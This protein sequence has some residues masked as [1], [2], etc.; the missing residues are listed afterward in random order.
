MMRGVNFLCFIRPACIPLL[1][2][3]F[4]VN[5]SIAQ[6]EQYPPDNPSDQN[7]PRVSLLLSGGGTRASAFSYGVLYQLSKICYSESTIR[8]F[9]GSHPCGEGNSL[10]ERAEIISAVSGG[11]IT[12]AY[13]ATHSLDR[14]TEDFPH[15]LKETDLKQKLLFKAR[16]W[17]I[18]K[19]LRPPVLLLTSAIDTA[20]T[21]LTTPLFFL[22][23]HPEFTPTATMALTDGIFE[24]DQLQSVF[25]QAFFNRTTL[26]SLSKDINSG[27]SP[28]GIGGKRKLLINATDIANGRTFTFDQD[29]F[30][31]MGTE[32]SYDSFPL[33]LAVAASSSLPGVFA[34]V[35]MEKYLSRTDPTR[36][37]IDRCPIML[38]D[39]VRP[40][41]LVDGGVGD[42]LGISAVLR[43]I[44]EEKR[45]DSTKRSQT[46]LL[47][48]VNA[49]TE[50]QSSLP[51][52]SG[53]LDNSF[54]SL[55]RDKTDLSR[56]VASGLLDQFGFQTIELK[57]S[58]I[59]TAPLVDKLVE[60]KNAPHPSSNHNNSLLQKNSME[61]GFA[62]TEMSRK[63][64]ADLTQAGMAPSSE[65]IDTLIAAGR[66]AVTARSKEISR[67][68]RAMSERVYAPVCDKISNPAREYCWPNEFELPHLA[69][70]RIGP[71]AQILAD[72][73]ARF[74]Q[75]T[76]LNRADLSF[77]LKEI[78]LAKLSQQLAI[79]SAATANGGTD[80]R[81]DLAQARKLA[82][83]ILAQ[84]SWSLEIDRV[85]EELHG[86]NILR[87]IPI[88]VE[89]QKSWHSTLNQLQDVVEQSSISLC[90]AEDDYFS[91][92][93]QQIQKVIPL[94]RSGQLITP[95][96]ACP[97]Q[98][99]KHSGRDL[100]RALMGVL[101]GGSNDIKQAPQY[102]MAKARLATWLDQWENTRHILYEGLSHFPDHEEMQGV[103]GWLLLTAQKDYQHAVDHLRQGLWLSRNLVNETERSQVAR[104]TQRQLDNQELLIAHFKVLQ[105][106]FKIS[107][108]LA[109]A[110]A[111][112]KIDDNPRYVSDE[113][114]RAWEILHFPVLEGRTLLEVLESNHKDKAR[115]SFTSC[116][117]SKETSQFKFKP[118]GEGKSCT[119]LNQVLLE[120]PALMRIL[121]SLISHLVNSDSVVHT[122]V[123]IL[124][125]KEIDKDS[126]GFISCELN[127]TTS[128]FKFR[129]QNKD[130]SCA[131]LNHVLRDHP[132]FTS[133]WQKLILET[134]SV[135]QED[136]RILN[137]ILKSKGTDM[138]AADLKSCEFDETTGR[139]K[140]K[141]QNT[142]NLCARLNQG[143]REH[144]ALTPIF[145]LL[146]RIDSE[147][148]EVIRQDIK[149]M[150]MTIREELM[151]NLGLERAQ[152]YARDVYELYR[153]KRASERF[154]VPLSS[155]SDRLS[156]PKK[157]AFWLEAESAGMRGF[158][159]LIKNAKQFCPEREAGML[160]AEGLF[161]EAKTLTTHPPAKERYEFLAATA[162]ALK[163]PSSFP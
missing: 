145:T 5:D 38:S 101:D 37:D 163:C 105:N 121:P 78:Y 28:A 23:I 55:I 75:Q 77:S 123:E 111:P 150:R 118:E 98:I 47:I 127:E 108:S 126:Q 153:Q 33:S 56:I 63:V 131:W 22:P 112:M 135:V 89:T 54:D 82:M 95:S 58:D 70:N 19:F 155:A 13:F 74:K 71:L 41:L 66:H 151:G 106:R 21:I 94:A 119:W 157:L 6:S 130:R 73:T 122:F 32:G 144:P 20:I 113:Q 46:N 100:V 88:T 99:G 52:L 84:T 50:M 154:A 17:S 12:A 141:P 110:T 93:L 114:A 35:R 136:I 134:D 61:Q 7:G 159:A 90:L 69:S 36:F 85:T 79:K 115:E 104:A 30:R 1:I 44:F 83:L 42:N 25:D 107:L 62:L 158:V 8:S 45:L 138:G 152:E 40:P 57:L 29:T 120:H 109:L 64:L 129:P 143:V 125:S 156:V 87:A 160:E 147:V 103:L 142:G 27:T 97:S 76:A 148:E 80:P 81:E 128:R 116:D 132:A 102:Y 3:L 139:F 72:R 9:E 49:G 24:P 31:C 53:V 48:I 91:T 68:I 67:T 117:F 51:G 34:P 86:P 15:I 124:E 14:F 26:G 59:V 2:L 4:F 11:S 162:K 60:E 92:L 39:K 140:L 133:D 161:V 137:K 43:T 18:G 146:V 65:H 149:Q 10:L 16:P 96:V